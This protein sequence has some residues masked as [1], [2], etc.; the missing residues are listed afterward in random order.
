MTTLKTNVILPSFIKTKTITYTNNLNS[1]TA[2]PINVLFG[3]KNSV[4][5]ADQ[6]THNDCYFG[7][8]DDN[9]IADITENYTGEYDTLIDATDKI[10]SRN[11]FTT[12][13]NVPCENLLK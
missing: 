4:Q 12:G 9:K 5:N 3:S 2:K 8:I 11:I 6:G 1:I 13:P 10:I 7:A